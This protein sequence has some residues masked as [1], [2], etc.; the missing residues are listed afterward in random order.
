MARVVVSLISLLLAF[1]GVICQAQLA[2]VDVD[3]QELEDTIQRLRE[4]F[5]APVQSKQELEVSAEAS[6]ANGSPTSTL[7]LAVKQEECHVLERFN[8]TIQPGDY[9]KISIDLNQLRSDGFVGVVVASNSLRGDADIFTF[10]DREKRHK[11]LEPS[12]FPEPGHADDFEDYAGFYLASLSIVDHT[13]LEAYIVPF[14][15]DPAEVDVIVY[16]TDEECE[17]SVSITLTGCADPIYPGSGW[18]PAELGPDENAG[19][20][21]GP[22]KRGFEQPDRG[23]DRDR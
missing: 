22:D 21:P 19:A 23:P 6:P 5:L 14:G 9:R 12:C 1:N 4:G 16:A 11:S 13:L 18:E 10:L 3:R 20:R 8:A 17:P 7:P 2:T 15:S